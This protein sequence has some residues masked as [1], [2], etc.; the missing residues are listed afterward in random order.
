MS[1]Q[2]ERASGF[3]EQVIPECNRDFAIIEGVVRRDLT[4][5]DE[6]DYY[7]DKYNET[8]PVLKRISGS[9]QLPGLLDHILA[10]YGKFKLDWVI[11]VEEFKHSALNCD[12]C[13]DRYLELNF[14]HIFKMLPGFRTMIRREQRE[15]RH[16]RKPKH[17]EREGLQRA[18][19]KKYANQP[20]AQRPKLE[21]LTGDEQLE[22]LIR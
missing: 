4:F 15:I 10:K 21:G 19:D 2:S 9:Q 17:E 20:P 14:E 16:D 3:E 5:R 8:M 11:D 18:L 22:L 6:E 13:F 7:C 1:A 12:R